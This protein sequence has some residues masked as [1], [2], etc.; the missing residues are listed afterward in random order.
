MPGRNRTTVRRL[1]EF[2][3]YDRAAVDGV[4]V[5]GLV[6]HVGIVDDGAPIVIPMVY[7]A[8]GDELYLHGS[9]AS[10]LLRALAAATPLCA[11]V[12][13][14][15]GI[16]L[17]RS[18]FN[19]SMSY[20]SVVVQGVARRVDDEAERLGALRAMLEHLVPGHFEEQRPPSPSELRQ[21]VVVALPLSETSVKVSTGP[22]DDEEDD[23]ALPQWA[24]ELPLVMEPGTPVPDPR[25][26]P[27]TPVPASVRGF[28]AAFRTR[29]ATG[30][31]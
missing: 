17:A 19:T 14:V 13:V 26:A 20:R 28:P 3:R 29:R 23:Y 6:A 21:T 16:L 27:G 18:A 1:P 4:L 7:A 30:T 12:T 22:P 31:T 11:T 8:V 2:A 25:L 10:R 24:G 15:D 5:A 9:V